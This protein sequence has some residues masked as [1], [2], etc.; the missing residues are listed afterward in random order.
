MRY[1]LQDTLYYTDLLF[2]TFNAASLA[3]GV[4]VCSLGSIIV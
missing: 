4:L 1:L 3:L 2:S